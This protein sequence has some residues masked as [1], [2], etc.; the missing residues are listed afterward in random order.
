[1]VKQR[2]V[3]CYLKEHRRTTYYLVLVQFQFLLISHLKCSRVFPNGNA[4][5]FLA[6]LA[7]AESEVDLEMMY[8]IQ[9][10]VLKGVFLTDLNEPTK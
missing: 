8:A 2:P 5:I 6:Q 9:V 4:T 10:R 1:M 7:D 3:L